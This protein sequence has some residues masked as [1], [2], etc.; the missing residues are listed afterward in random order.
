MNRKQTNCPNCGAPYEYGLNKCPYC[1]TIYFNFSI[2]DFDSKKP[3]FL[4][5][6]KDN[7]LITQKVIPTCTSMEMTTDY[8]YATGREGNTKL[9]MIADSTLTTEISFTSIPTDNNVLFTMI[10]EY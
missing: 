6:K 3:I 7:V 4:T 10:Q 9:A 8:I 1:G 2:I 5:I